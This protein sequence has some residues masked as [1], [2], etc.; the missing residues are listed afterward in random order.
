MLWVRASTSGME[1]RPI[2]RIEKMVGLCECYIEEFETG[3]GKKVETRRY[4]DRL[5]SSFDITDALGYHS[6]IV[7]YKN[8]MVTSTVFIESRI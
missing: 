4:T 6:S 7:P 5:R 8:E 1:T 2:L 3:S